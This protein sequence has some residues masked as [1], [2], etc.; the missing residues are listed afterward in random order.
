[1]QPVEVGS[2][3]NVVLHSVQVLTLKQSV[4]SELQIK[5]VSVVSV[6]T[7]VVSNFLML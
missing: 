6:V 1:M 3:L 5:E 2:K 7:G 4:Q